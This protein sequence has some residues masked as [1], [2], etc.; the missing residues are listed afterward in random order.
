MCGMQL[1]A[2]SLEN[3]FGSTL[4]ARHNLPLVWPTASPWHP[5]RRREE[6]TGLVRGNTIGRLMVASVGQRLQTPTTSC[7]VEQSDG[8]DVILGKARTAAALTAGTI[9]G[10]SMCV[11]P[12]RG[13]TYTRK[14]LAAIFGATLWTRCRRPLRRGQKSTWR[15]ELFE[16][17]ALERRLAERNFR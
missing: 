14:P 4:P 11:A 10:T 15:I 6:R 3:S 16:V 9:N 1:K 12:G 2:I 17:L 8:D 13:I 5:G 7:A